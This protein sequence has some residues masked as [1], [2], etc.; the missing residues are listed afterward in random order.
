ML[1][2]VKCCV[3]HPS[4]EFQTPSHCN[5]LFLHWMSR[6]CRGREEVEHSITVTT[7]ITALLAAD[8]RRTSFPAIEFPS[9]Q[10]ELGTTTAGAGGRRC[11]WGAYRA[12]CLSIHPPQSHFLQEKLSALLSR[13]RSQ[14][15]SGWGRLLGSRCLGDVALWGM[16]VSAPT[17]LRGERVSPTLGQ[18]KSFL[19]I[20]IW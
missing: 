2:T 5:A 3:V 4:T 7:A 6:R 17:D 15:P 19:Q 20:L 12:V 10:G 13:C 8:G 11:S 9:K 16:D 18:I 1:T 14:H